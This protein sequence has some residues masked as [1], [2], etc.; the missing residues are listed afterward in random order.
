[1]AKEAFSLL[2]RILKDKKASLSGTLLCGCECCRMSAEMVKRLIAME[3]W[4]LR[5]M[6]RV[7]WTDRE[8]NEELLGGVGTE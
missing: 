1:M 5:K 2:A 3:I 8:S 4:F 6:L 7:L